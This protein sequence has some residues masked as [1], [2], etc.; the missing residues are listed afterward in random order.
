LLR[1]AAAL[2]ATLAGLLAAALLLLAWLV[3]AAL[4]PGLIALLLLARLLIRIL[5][6]ILILRHF[7][8]SPT[9]L[10]GVTRRLRRDSP[11]NKIT[12][13]EIIR[14]VCNGMRGTLR[15]PCR[16]REPLLSLKGRNRA[17]CRAATEKVE[18]SAWKFSSSSS[19]TAS[20]SVPSM[21]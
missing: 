18:L 20:R 8:I 3:I 16:F 17:V 13:H 4:L 5:V 9:L 10:A 19:S 21:A 6:G 2:L 7:N 14:S 1:L 15:V 11:A 12:S